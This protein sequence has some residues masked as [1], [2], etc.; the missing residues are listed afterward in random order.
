MSHLSP[1]DQVFMLL[2]KRSQPLHVAY[3]CMLKPPANAE[4]DFVQK[5]A[6]HL[7][8]Y[9][10]PHAPFNR[11]L[12]RRIGR[13]SWTKDTDFDIEQHVTHLALPKPGGFREL[14]AMVSRVHASHLDRAYPLWRHYIIEGLEDGRIAT[15]SKIHHAVCDGIAGTR[16]IL[17]SMSPDREAQLPPAWAIPPREPRVRNPVVATAGRLPMMLASL[18]KLA[19]QLRMGIRDLRE[20]HPDAIGP[21][22]AP[23]CIINQKISAS[24][25]YAAQSYSTLRAKNIAKALG[26]TVNDVV[27]AMCGAALR[28]FLL[29]L[30]ALPQQPLIAGV[31]VSL[32]RDRGE[33]GNQLTFML[34]NLGTHL[35]D[36]GERIAQVRRSVDYNKRRFMQM[37]PA[38]S[39]A[40]SVAMLGPGLAMSSV[41]PQRQMFNVIISNTPGPRAPL[42]WQGC[43]LEGMYPVS[44]LIDGQALNIALTSLHDRLDFGVLACRRTLPGVQALLEYL[45]EGLDELEQLAARS[46]AAPVEVPPTGSADSSKHR[47]QLARSRQAANQ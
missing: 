19:R 41:N 1:V 10:A 6:A 35:A 25:R 33:V 36:P 4:P 17:K 11:R 22:D 8:T 13:M 3:L 42:Y 2:E 14:L 15:Y 47:L 9:G 45:G 39:L 12:E 18:P 34:V 23:R 30:N 37:T 32:R 29:S 26:C 43:E 24:R 16:L 20:N 46:E 28:K 5:L 38:E 44:V 40:Y 7:R 27:L 31:P 21:F